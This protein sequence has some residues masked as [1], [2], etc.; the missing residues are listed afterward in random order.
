MK[1]TYGVIGAEIVCWVSESM[2]VTSSSSYLHSL[3]VKAGSS[4][5]QRFPGTGFSS[6]AAPT[7]SCVQGISNGGR[8]GF[9]EC[10]RTEICTATIP[11]T[12]VR[13]R[14]MEV[15][16]SCG[17]EVLSRYGFLREI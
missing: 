5:V 3:E 14:G 13:M 4:E 12:R 6:C 9:P 1:F 15:R 17:S 8:N 2:H 10:V 7:F 11:N 16:S